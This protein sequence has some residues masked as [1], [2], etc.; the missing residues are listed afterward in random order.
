[1]GTRGWGAGHQGGVTPHSHTG[2]T[3]LMSQAPLSAGCRQQHQKPKARGGLKGP[4]ARAACPPGLASLFC[5]LG[6]D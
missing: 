6:P 4:G 3:F 2:A 1:M 5:D